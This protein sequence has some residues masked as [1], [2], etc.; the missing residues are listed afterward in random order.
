MKGRF[1]EVLQWPFQKRVCLAL[2]NTKGGHAV[3]KNIEPDPRLHYF[4]RPDSPRNVGYGY[5]KFIQLTRLLHEESEYVA[6]G[7]IFLQSRVFDQ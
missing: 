4:H 7:A 6:G 3:V 1:D 5:P 2:L